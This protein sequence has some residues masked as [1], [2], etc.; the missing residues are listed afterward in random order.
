VAKGGTGGGCDNSGP[1]GGGGGGVVHQLPGPTVCDVD[2]NPGQP[3]SAT[4]GTNL[5]YR[6]A[7]KGTPGRKP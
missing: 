4:G 2:I 1:G 7:T 5:P 3:G 6:G